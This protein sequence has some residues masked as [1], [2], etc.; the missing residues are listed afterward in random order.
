MS[1]VD[2]VRH[3][4]L[5]SGEAWDD[6]CD[7]LKLAGRIVVRETPDADER[8]R[9]EGFRYLTRIMLISNMRA[10]ERALPDGPRPIGVVP[11]PMK[12]GIGVQSPNQDHVMQPVDGRRRYRITGQRGSVG[13]GR[14]C[15]TFY[16]LLYF[17]YVSLIFYYVSIGFYFVFP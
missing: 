5:M 16:F 14:F 13:D 9:V 12:G 1:D 6:F 2:Q 11:P 3:D 17:L 15:E 10:I 7:T 4:R 8:D